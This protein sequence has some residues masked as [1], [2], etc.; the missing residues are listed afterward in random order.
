VEA[1]L[2]AGISSAVVLGASTF[3]A[4]SAKQDSGDE[5]QFWISARRIEFQGLIHSVQ[6]WNEIVA[7]NSGM[8]CFT[9]GTSCAS[10][11]TT[12]QPLKLPIDGTVLDGS[13]STVGM[14]NKGDFCNSFDAA[15]GISTCPVGL[16]LS[17]IALCD[18]A[19]CKHAQPKIMISFRIKEPSTVLQDLKSYDLVAYK[20]P[21]LESLN[22]ICTAMHGTLTGT[23][24]SVAS[25]T[26]ACDTANTL[27]L[28]ATYP[29][30]FKPDG[31]VDC[32][33]P[34]PGSCAASDVAI[35]FGADGGIRCAPACL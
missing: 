25:L 23:T 27:G 4:S 18:D 21:K 1:I 26:S 7:Q 34:D 35:G 11:S 13:T 22:E 20:D 17:W 16:Q 29:I 10:V 9:S 3:F 19:M 24:C 2:A 28:G 33:K 31:S 5:R 14:T 8:G 15:V 6:G 32:G 12:P 30:G